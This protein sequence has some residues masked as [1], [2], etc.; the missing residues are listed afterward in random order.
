[1]GSG[2]SGGSGS[3]P[4]GAKVVAPVVMILAAGAV[5]LA[6]QFLLGGEEPEGS[7]GAGVA[8][9][10]G[11]GGSR[12]A[13]G[14]DDR[15]GDDLIR[16][17]LREAP[18]KGAGSVRIAS[19]NIENLFDAHDDPAISG[20]I[21]DLPMRKPDAQLSAAADALRRLDADIVALQEIE[22][23]AALLWF[24]DGWLRDM[25][26]AHV[27]S[28]DAGDGRGIEQAVLSRFPITR[29]ENWPGLE[30]GG[31]HP[32]LWGSE[33]NWQAGEPLRFH[34][35]PLRV[36]VEIPSGGEPYALTLFVVHHKS[37]RE[38]GYWRE[39]EAEGLVR[40]M[41]ALSTEDP[42]AN[43]L[44]LGDFNAMQRDRSVQIYFDAGLRDA[45]TTRDLSDRFV[46]HESGRPIDAI[47][48]NAEAMEEI[49]P[50]SGFVLGTPARPRGADWRTTPAPEGYAADHYPVAVDL[51]PRE[52]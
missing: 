31:E 34:R 33:P 46:T 17:G 23:E 42:D 18:A 19:Y 16:F 24:R 38:G 15:A 47:L 37:G 2:G 49:R 52:E 14:A 12:P 32:E 3:R 8:P 1:M 5:L 10:V 7:A 41:G 29:A 39:A 22:S 48:A 51:L 30:L 36:D 43:V 11:A 44:V 6:Q 26:Y 20:E 28:L 50:G 4:A 27:A 45:L 9:A 13:R 21:D 35:S 40:L 25:G